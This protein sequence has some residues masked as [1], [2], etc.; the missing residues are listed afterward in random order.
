MAM[1]LDAFVETLVERLANVMEKKAIMV[2]GVK[3]ELQKLWQR[4]AR[5]GN[6]L[7]DAEK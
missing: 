1:I 3:I 4:M 6:V 2:L 7:K 5:I